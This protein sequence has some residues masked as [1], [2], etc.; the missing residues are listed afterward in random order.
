MIARKFTFLPPGGILIDV[1]DRGDYDAFHLPGSLL[2]PVYRLTSVVPRIIPD[3][4]VPLF[5]YCDHGAKSKAGAIQLR[6]L[7]YKNVYD[8]GGMDG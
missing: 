4:T 3:V 1:R 7:G 6:D 8:V 5:L 2:I